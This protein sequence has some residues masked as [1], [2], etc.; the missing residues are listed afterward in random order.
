MAYEIIPIERGSR[1]IIPYIQHTN[2]GFGHRSGVFSAEEA[3]FCWGEDF[4]WLLYFFLN[5]I[6]KTNN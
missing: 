4:C 1:N 6:G 3:D 5:V 2:Q